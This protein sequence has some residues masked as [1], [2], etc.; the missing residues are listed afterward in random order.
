MH[1]FDG[2]DLLRYAEDAGFAEVRLDLEAVVAR[3]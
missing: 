1:D 2:R 3:G